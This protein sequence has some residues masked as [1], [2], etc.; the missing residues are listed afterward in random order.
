M[1]RGGQDTTELTAVAC[2]NYCKHK[3]SEISG[4]TSACIVSQGWQNHAISRYRSSAPYMVKDPDHM[5]TQFWKGPTFLRPD[6][7]EPDE[8]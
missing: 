3:L 4:G 5:T 2:W 6:Q 7:G 8:L 1:S